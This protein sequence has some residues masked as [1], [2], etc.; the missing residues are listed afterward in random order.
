LLLSL[1]FSFLSLASCQSD[2][3]DGNYFTRIFIII[4]ENTAYEEAIKDPNFLE[5]ANKG[6]RM[7]NYHYIYK[8]SQPNYIQMIAASNLGCISNSNI[9]FTETTKTLVSLLENAKISWKG[10]M[11]AFPSFCFLG[12]FS[13]PY[14]RKHNPF[15]SFLAITKNISQCQKVV[16][17]KEF[18]SDLTKDRLPQYSF[19]S[20]DLNND[21]H[22]TGVAY[23]GKHLKATVTDRLHAFP[24]R[25]L[26]VVT[27]DEGKGSGLIYCALYGVGSLS[28]PANSKTATY[29]THDSLIKTC[30]VNW[31]LPSLERQDV[32]ANSFFPLPFGGGS[33]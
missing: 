10:Y 7:T 5:F 31:D 14:C 26:I 18:E 1:F 24:D 32:D 13:G 25:T 16:N 27:F 29:Y 9:E 6:L 3:I 11:E 8:P 21:G 19:Y 4:Y 20:P 30:E 12:G 17:A 28:I 2:I 33:N 23:A 22:D 15:M